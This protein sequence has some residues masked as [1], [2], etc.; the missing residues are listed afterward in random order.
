MPLASGYLKAAAEAEADLRRATDIRIFNFSGGDPTMKV[1]GSMFGGEVPE[2]AGFSIFGWNYHL[3]GRVSE[4]YRQL[5]PD[6]WVIWGGT[7]VTNQAKRVFDNFP[8]VDVVVNGEGEFTF[9]ELIRAY[10]AGRSRHDLGDIQGLSFK[11]PDGEVVT[12]PTRPRIMDL[13]VVPSPILTGAIPTGGNGSGFPYD[14]AL[15]ETN[16]GCP[17]ACAFCYWGGAIGQKMR[18]FSTE[19]LSE[20]VAYLARRGAET[21]TL[22][23]SNFGMLR[24]DEQFLEICVKARERYGFP[25]NIETSWAKNKGKLFYRLVSRMK[26]AGFH[27]SFNLALQSL[28]EPVLEQ[29]GRKNMKVNDWVD[30]ARWLEKEGMDL[31]AELIWGCPG[32]TYDSFLAGYD[33]LSE[34]VTR[35]ATYPHLMLPNTTYTE[36]KKEFGIVSWRTA[37]HDFE[38][39]LS[40][41]T[42]TLEENRKMHRFLFWSRVFS[43][44]LVLRHVWLPL[45][46]VCGMTQSQVL[47]SLDEWC[48]RQD[49]PAL[50]ALCALRDQVVESLDPGSRPIEDALHIIYTE[51]ALDP[52]MERWWDEAVLPQVDAPHRDFFVDLFRYDWVTRPIY[53]LNPRVEPLAPDGLSHPGLRLVEINQEQYYV[54]EGVSFNHDVGKALEAFKRAGTYECTP[55]PVNLTFYYKAGF[56]NDMSLYHNAHNQAFCGSTAVPYQ[57]VCPGGD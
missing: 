5:K 38:L 22:C 26:E 4:T 47:L 7:H 25:K 54:R 16:R 55:G 18:S 35:V 2:V 49:D 30:L 14:Y 53:K 23:D 34:H 32:E 57:A 45:R 12:T 20:E 6:G 9:I 11:G 17:Y 19:R 41:N 42:M 46:R 31:Y 39:V 8:A 37:E 40:H 43:E 10:L 28:E 51:P 24:A 50:V 36:K 13:D 56:C 1:I 48:D 33:R 44:H 29:M 27:S 3:F 15:M 52:L 21:I